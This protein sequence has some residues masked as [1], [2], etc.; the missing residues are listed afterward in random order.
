MA[1]TPVGSQFGKGGTGLSDGTLKNHL[2]ELVE[3]VDGVVETVGELPEPIVYVT[4]EDMGL[5][6]SEVLEE[7]R[8]ATTVVVDGA[9]ENTDIAVAGLAVADTITLCLMFDTGV[10]SVLT[11]SAQT[12]GNVQFATAT[13]GNKIV[14]S[15]LT[16]PVEA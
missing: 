14:I 5:V 3:A 12:L 6:I 10:P 8:G 15:Y 11:P 16:A 13:T 4:E 2:E 7:V 9:A 1:L